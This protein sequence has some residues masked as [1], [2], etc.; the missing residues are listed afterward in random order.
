MKN[1]VCFAI[2]PKGK[3]IPPMNPSEYVHEV[4]KNGP[5]NHKETLS[6]LLCEF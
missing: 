4:S 5:I 3:K 6:L 1:L 2:G